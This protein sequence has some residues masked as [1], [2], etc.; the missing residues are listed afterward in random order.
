MFRKND[1][2]IEIRNGLCASTASFYENIIINI[3]T[4]Q[5]PLQ[6]MFKTQFQGFNNFKTFGEMCS[7]TTKK[8]I[9]GKL[10]D[11]GTVGLLVGYPQNHVENVYRIFKLKT[12]K[13]IKSRY[14][15]WLNL[16]YG[17]WNKSKNAI[18]NS[19]DEDLSDSE[20]A[21]IAAK[22][23]AIPE[24]ASTDGIEERKYKKALKEASK[25]KS[26]FNPDP[27]KLIELQNS[28]RESVR[29]KS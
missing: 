8:S 7:G 4:Q 29:R 1:P 26:W 21:D 9:Q 10:N 23:L 17:N 15:I 3:G 2:Y 6:L 11:R 25:L 28:G 20:S 12:K 22:Y 18:K 14:L 5:S 16:N 24:E 19:D 27:L 13:I